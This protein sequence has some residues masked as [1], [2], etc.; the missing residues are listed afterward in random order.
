M[1]A[2]PLILLVFALV[3]AAIAVTFAPLYLDRFRHELSRAEELERIARGLDLT[4][5]RT[6]PAYPG[7]SAVRYPFE[8][9]SRGVE[10]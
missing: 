3:G 7:S 8:L 5:S 2:V 6:D 1:R 9:F 4:F 10:Q